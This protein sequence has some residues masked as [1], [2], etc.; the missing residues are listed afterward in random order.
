MVTA[1]CMNPSVD[2]TVYLEKF[3]VSATNIIGRETRDVGG[4]GINVA[5]ALRRLGVPSSCM[6]IVGDK[7]LSEVIAHLEKSGVEA[8]FMT[9]SGEMRTNLKVVDEESHQ[10]TELN[11]RGPE[12]DTE[13][14]TLFR[15]LVGERAKKSRYIVF[16]G[17]MPPGTPKEYYRDLMSVCPCRAVL[18]THGEML[19]SALEAKPYLIKPNIKE[20]EMTVGRPLQTMRSILEAA[21]EMQKRGA[22]TVL[23][24]MGAMGAMLCTEETALYSPAIS[25]P[26]RSTVGAGDCMVAGFLSGIIQSGDIKDAFRFGC[27][28]G[29]ASVMTEGTQLMEKK[30]FD[31]LLCRV[32][33]QSV[34]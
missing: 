13:M 23:V 8:R 25:V 33:L 32:S 14:L 9:V 29:A 3:E 5:I 4:K 26:V 11:E 12:V 28:A 30:D 22:Q 31:E 27:A 19:T 1:I 2:K 34:Q 6:G 18:D 10:V 20:L 7:S 24:S 17:A 16:T 15:T 21:R